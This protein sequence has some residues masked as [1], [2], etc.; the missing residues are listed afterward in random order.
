MD[1]E[2]LKSLKCKAFARSIELFELDWFESY[3][4]YGIYSSEEDIRWLFGIR[5]KVLHKLSLQ[6]E[7]RLLN[8]RQREH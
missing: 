3:E 6:L 1:T 7:K 5:V 8:E 4:K 2:H